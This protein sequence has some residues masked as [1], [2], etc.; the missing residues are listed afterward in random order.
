MPKITK[1]EGPSNAAD[2]DAPERSDRTAAPGSVDELAERAYCAYANARDWIAYNGYDLPDWWNV[3][4]DVA[5][6]W[7]AVARELRGAILE[8]FGVQPVKRRPADDRDE[9]DGDDELVNDTGEGYPDSGTAADVESWVAGNS[10]RAAYALER[11][12]ERPGGARAGLSAA[13]GKL[14]GGA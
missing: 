13:L 6:G 1:A 14:T 4:A 7:R 8:P 11:E 3:N 12:Q 9:S 10:D 2:P 5:E